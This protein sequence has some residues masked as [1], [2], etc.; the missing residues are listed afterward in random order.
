M[1]QYYPKSDNKMDSRKSDR[2]KSAHLHELFDISVKGNQKRIN[3]HDKNLQ[4][5]IMHAKVIEISCDFDFELFF[6]YSRMII[7]NAKKCK[8]LVHKF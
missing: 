8:N 5:V 7:Q 2:K 4:P 3:Q 1:V 6:V